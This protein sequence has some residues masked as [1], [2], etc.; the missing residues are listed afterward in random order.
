MRESTETLC[1]IAEEDSVVGVEGSLCVCRGKLGGRTF[2]YP[3]SFGLDYFITPELGKKWSKAMMEQ[4]AS[5]F[6]SGEVDD[7]AFSVPN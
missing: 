7:R 6:I 4:I 3:K 1:I 2:V 5:F